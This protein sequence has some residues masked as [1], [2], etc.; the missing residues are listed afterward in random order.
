M[1][2]KREKETKD[3][4]NI[5]KIR[6]QLLKTLRKGDLEGFKIVVEGIKRDLTLDKTKSVLD[7]KDNR[8]WTL[9]HE[10]C[11]SKCSIFSSI[12]IDLGADVNSLTLESSTPLVVAAYNGRGQ[13]VQELIRAGA[14]LN[15]R[16][17]ENKT[18]LDIARERGKAQI[19]DILSSPT[20]VQLDSTLLNPDK[21]TTQDTKRAKLQ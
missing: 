2:N 4:S 19:V 5:V 8:G 12:I 3:E 16:D 13:T 20:K 6:R 14:L 17:H 15:L 11:R 9:L 21:E 10:S 1:D 7:I 18:A